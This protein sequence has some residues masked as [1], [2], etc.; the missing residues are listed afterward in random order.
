MSGLSWLTRQH[1]SRLASIIH[2]VCVNVCRMG[3]HLVLGSSTEGERPLPAHC[4]WVAAE[5]LMEPRVQ[6]APCWAAAAVPRETLEAAPWLGVASSELSLAAAQGRW[7][8]AFEAKR[9]GFVSA[10]EPLLCR[11]R[12]QREAR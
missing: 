9:K 5:L 2:L 10:A 12:P 4:L 6:P 3:Q 8:D 11:R 7:G 1:R